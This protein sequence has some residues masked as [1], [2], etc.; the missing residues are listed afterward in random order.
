MSMKLFQSQVFQTVIVGVF[1]VVISQYVLR[2]IIEPIQVYKRVIVK[3]DNKLKFYSNVIINPPF[4]GQ[5]LT[6]DYLSARQE[7]R[8]LSCELE[9]SYKMLP[10]KRFR[11]DKRRISVVVKDLIWLSNATGH[12]DE[13]NTVNVPLMA[14]D[15]I[16]NIRK[17][18][19]IDKL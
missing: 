17:N 3:I 2:F 14:D 19:R 7:L 13:T 5:P 12:R 4:G 1:V 11:R 15:K 16:K 8:E 6:K 18:L 9:S 10:F